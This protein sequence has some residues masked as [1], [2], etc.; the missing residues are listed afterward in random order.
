MELSDDVS[1]FVVLPFSDFGVLLLLHPERYLLQNPLKNALDV[2]SY[3]S[4]TKVGHLLVESSVVSTIN[5]E[6][7]NNFIGVFKRKSLLLF[8]FRL[9]SFLTPYP[10]FQMPFPFF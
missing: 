3:F 2:G 8:Y 7:S 5:T 10:F 6:Q 1:L 9:S 4:L